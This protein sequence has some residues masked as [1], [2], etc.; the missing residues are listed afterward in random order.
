M[1]ELGKDGHTW[2]D[3]GLMN[4]NGKARTAFYSSLEANRIEFLKNKENELIG[5]S[6]LKPNRLFRIDRPKVVTSILKQGDNTL[7]LLAHSPAKQFVASLMITKSY[8]DPPVPP[9]IKTLVGE[10]SLLDH[11]FTLYVQ[12]RTTMVQAIAQPL[13]CP[14]TKN[15]IRRPVRGKF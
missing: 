7:H 3:Q 5:I 2:P 13:T 4:L 12:S 6:G 1:I 8:K 11:L 9:P 14:I 10:A 15:R